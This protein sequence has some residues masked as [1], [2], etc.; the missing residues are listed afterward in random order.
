M[1]IIRVRSDIPENKGKTYPFLALKIDKENISKVTVT[2]Q[3]TDDKQY[4]E[5][6]VVNGE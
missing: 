4:S 3:G 2:L 6:L 1:Q 5:T